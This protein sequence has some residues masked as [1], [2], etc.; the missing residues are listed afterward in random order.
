VLRDWELPAANIVALLSARHGR[1]ARTA[2]FLE[3]LH[4]LLTPAPWR[5]KGVA[6]TRLDATSIGNEKHEKRRRASSAG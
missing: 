5:Q 2:R 3:H 4:T 6:P 1:S